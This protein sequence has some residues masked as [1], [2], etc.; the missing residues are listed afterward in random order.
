MFKPY[1]LHISNMEDL[2]RLV[3]GCTALSVF[4]T[5]HVHT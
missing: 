5:H 4:F 3:G 2:Y 1:Y